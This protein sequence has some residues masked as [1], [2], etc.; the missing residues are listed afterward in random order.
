MCLA[1]V[2]HIKMS[3]SFADVLWEWLRMAQGA[4]ILYYVIFYFF[5]IPFGFF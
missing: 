4:G 3:S 1:R 5:V 2:L